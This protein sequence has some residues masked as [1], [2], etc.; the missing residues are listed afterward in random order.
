MYQ[1]K[2]S[3]CM[4][5]LYIQIFFYNTL[6]VASQPGYNLVQTVL[7]YRC[8]ENTQCFAIILP[9]KTGGYFMHAQTV[10]QITFCGYLE[11]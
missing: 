6:Y 7:Y 11:A 1:S 8:T 2:S 10:Y 5:I 9:L 3:V 4:D